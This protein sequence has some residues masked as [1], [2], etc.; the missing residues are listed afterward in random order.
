VSIHTYTVRCDDGGTC[1]SVSLIAL[2]HT[3]SVLLV[4][5]PGHPLDPPAALAPLKQHLL[6]PQGATLTTLSSTTWRELAESGPG[7]RGPMVRS[8]SIDGHDSGW[9]DAYAQRPLARHLDAARAW[10]RK[11][12]R[13]LIEA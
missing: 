12:C 7:H 2:D 1:L 13:H 6:D 8:L 11:N 10:V 5:L 3:S 4:E 9:C